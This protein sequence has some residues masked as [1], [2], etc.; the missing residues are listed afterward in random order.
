MP[1]HQWLDIPNPTIDPT[2]STPD[3]HGNVISYSGL[4]ATND[5]DTALPDVGVWLPYIWV[6]NP[7]LEGDLISER[8]L[9]WDKHLDGWYTSDFA[10][11]HESL[12]VTAKFITDPEHPDDALMPKHV[13]HATSDS[14]TPVDFP[15]TG[16]GDGPFEQE[17]IQP[18]DLLPFTDIGPLAAHGFKTFDVEFT[19]HWG[20]STTGAYRVG[21]QEIALVPNHPPGHG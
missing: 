4:R 9:T 7:P 14:P 2:H 10:G 3:I 19:F 15:T 13:A 21:Q 20:G 5:S 6:R 8:A 17:T 1:A 18:N 12:L 16:G 11:T